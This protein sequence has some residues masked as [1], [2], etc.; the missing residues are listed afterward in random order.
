MQALR[1][2]DHGGRD[3]VLYT[4]VTYPL[5]LEPMRS[6]GYCPSLPGPH[7]PSEGDLAVHALAANG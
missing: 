4:I 1:L 5:P 2:D 6:I 3:L 7:D